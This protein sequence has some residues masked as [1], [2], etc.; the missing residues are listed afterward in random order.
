VALKNSPK[1]AICMYFRNQ[2][3][4]SPKDEIKK[5]VFMKADMIRIATQI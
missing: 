2:K 4:L 5:G 1:W 3:A